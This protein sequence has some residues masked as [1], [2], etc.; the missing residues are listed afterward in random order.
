MHGIAADELAR[1]HTFSEVNMQK[2]RFTAAFG[3]TLLAGIFFFQNCSNVS[4]SS[5]SSS[6]LEKAGLPSNDPNIAPPFP[7]SSPPV[8]MCQS[9]AQNFEPKLMW[10]WASQLTATQ[11]PYFNQVMAAP[12]VSDLDG[13][14][15]PE[16]VFVS[17]T[18][19]PGGWYDPSTT[20][21]A[22]LKNGALRIVDGQTG[23]TKVTVADQAHAPMATT[24]PLLIDLDGDGKI[25][26][27][28][29]NYTQD[30]LIALNYD[31][32]PRWSFALPAAIADWCM[33]GPSASDLN[34]D[35]HPEVLVGNYVVGE[36]DDL[37]PQLLMTLDSVGATTCNTF[38]TVLDPANPHFSIVDPYAVHDNTGTRSFALSPS[39]G[40]MAVGKVR[41]DL[42]GNQIVKTADAH[43]YIYDGTTGA[44][45]TDINLL[46][47][48]QYTC[49][50]GTIG[51]GPASIGDFMGTGENQIAVA[52]GQYL[53][54]F[55]GTGKLLASSRTQDC[56]SEE[57]GMTA[58]D[59]DGDGIPEIL[60]GDEQYFRVF[61]MVNGALEVVAQIVNP[62]GT[63]LEYPVVADITG[64]GAA[65]ILVVSNNYAV[66]SF[67]QTAATAPDQAAAYLV[68]GVRAFTSSTALPWMPTRPS[69][70]QYHYNAALVNDRARVFDPSMSSQSWLGRTFKLNAQL[71]LGKPTCQK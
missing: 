70:N 1:M 30:H 6:F 44:Q 5:S 16:V 41:N 50:T 45:L 66:S 34:V 65:S 55:D 36:D 64:T 22:Y 31:G 59:F 28:Y 68:T 48:S 13:D 12:V 39:F 18:M 24:S 57:T 46:A 63:L 52:T 26:I 61:H 71:S 56:S 15:I 9:V 38:A 17:W 37:Q 25:E 51:G 21:P 29:V 62:S 33:A 35:G 54:I 3:F 47:L 60:Y 43:I 23:K 27:V 40:L 49:P 8:L 58:F 11:L 69:W 14:G 20:N 42:T 7:I 32:S 2:R 10:D 67:Y 4:F 53:M 19:S